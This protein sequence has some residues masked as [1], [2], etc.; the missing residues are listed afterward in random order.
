[1]GISKI[2]NLRPKFAKTSRFG[3]ILNWYKSKKSLWIIEHEICKMIFIIDSSRRKSFFYFFVFYKYLIVSNK[4]RTH[5]L[6]FG[7]FLTSKLGQLLDFRSIL[8]ITI[9]T[10]YLLEN[11]NHLP[12]LRCTLYFF[13]MHTLS[14]KF[15]QYMN[16]RPIWI[17][18]QTN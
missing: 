5:L 1:M 18:S 14:E 2:G 7:N 13:L 16:R 15:F 12:G 4:R 11:E 10:V 3:K 8:L 9:K 6:I 17:K